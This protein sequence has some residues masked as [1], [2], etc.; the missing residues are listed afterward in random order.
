MF[1]LYLNRE[2][3]DTQTGDVFDHEDGPLFLELMYASYSEARQVADKLDEV[4][5]KGRVEVE[6]VQEYAPR[7]GRY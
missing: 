7:M 4:Y 3:R 6:A 1:A 2:I 5:G